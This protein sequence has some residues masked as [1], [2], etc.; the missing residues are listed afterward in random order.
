MFHDKNDIINDIQDKC[1]Q[2]DLYWYKRG[3]RDYGVVGFL[4]GIGLITLIINLI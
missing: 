1:Y 4:L 2:N 3:A